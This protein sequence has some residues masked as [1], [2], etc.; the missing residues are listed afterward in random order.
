MNEL[1]WHQ[2]VIID[3]DQLPGK[4][5]VKLINL[6]NPFLNCNFVIMDFLYGAIAKE[7]M[8]TQLKIQDLTIVLSL[9]KNS[10]QVESGD[11]FFLK[12]VLQ[13]GK[14]NQIIHL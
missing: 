8:Q 4:N 12:N 2:V 10:A 6:I 11:F 7:L 5:L 13:I 1:K 14:I 9:L 3:Q